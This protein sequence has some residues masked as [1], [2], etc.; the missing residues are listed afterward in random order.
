MPKKKKYHYKKRQAKKDLPQHNLPDGFWSQIGALLLVAIAILFVVA[1]F[2]AGGPVLEWL[3]NVAV[4]TIGYA[5]YIVPMI[6]IYVAIEIFKIEGNKLPLTVKIATFLVIVWFSALF[7]LLKGDSSE[8]TGGVIGN[9][10]NI[11]VLNMVNVGIAAFVYTLLIIVTLLYVMSISPA[12]LIKTI[13]NIIRPNSSEDDANTKIMKNVASIDGGLGDSNLS[14]NAAVPTIG[15]VKGLNKSKGK[16]DSGN[17]DKSGDDKPA[18]VTVSDPNWKFPSLDLLEKNQSPADP[19][20]VQANA[21]IIQDTLSEFDIEVKME[22]ANIGPRV[23]QF[24]LLPARGVRLDKIT[25]LEKNLARALE[26]DSLRIEAPIPGQKFVGIE[27]PNK[28]GADVRLH[29]I[30]NSKQWKKKVEP[31]TFAIGRDISGDIIL[32]DLSDMPHLLIAGQTKAGKSVMINALLMS[33]LYHNS[34]SDMKLILIDPKRVE[35]TAYED[36]PH[37]LTPIITE[38]EK[39]ISALKWCVQE[40]ERRYVLLSEHKTRT[41]QDYNADIKSKGGKVE[42]DDENGNLQEH[43][44]GAMPYIVIVIDELS[45]L[46]QAAPKDFEN[47]VIRLAQKGRAAGLHL[48]L[49][50]QSPRKDV[51]T[52]LIKANVPAKIAFAV[53]NQMESRIIID[54]NGAEKLLGRGDMLLSTTDSSR[55]RRVQGA[56]VSNKEVHDVMDHLRMQS[57]PQYNDQVISQP[58]HLNGKGGVVM[59]FDSGS[60]DAL[61]EEAVN[62]VVNTGKASASVLQRRLSV[63]YARAARL[64]DTMEE[65]GIVGPANGARPREVLI[66]SMDEYGISDDG[67][68]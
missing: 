46:K 53:S 10:I 45:D 55:I 2:N 67:D 31:L 17:I 40:M 54:Q 19:G 23:T 33:L 37:L 13:W 43:E 22:G 16:I 38:P 24:Q 50:T 66:D 64:I 28:K 52:G 48:V 65:Q 4:K 36:I 59:D 5:V 8:L 63:G 57:P 56:W 32:G 34:P 42:I 68:L 9:L 6:F 21:K 29:A 12:T 35:M 3:Y 26:A 60:D 41:I 51:I 25:A 44:N 39:V 62:L 58:V 14:I 30:L 11:G 61:Y 7:G 20:N 15:T 49:A 1:W 18:L 27:M 47:L